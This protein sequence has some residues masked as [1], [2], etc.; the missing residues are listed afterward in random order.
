MNMINNLCC[1]LFLW[2]ME[3]RTGFVISI[4]A[5]ETM[6]PRKKTRLMRSEGSVERR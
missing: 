5:I 3:R 6:P 4:P 1:L 2:W